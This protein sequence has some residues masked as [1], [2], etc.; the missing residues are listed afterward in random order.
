MVRWSPN[1]LYAHKLEKLSD[2][3]AFKVSSLVTQELGQ[4]SK[5]QDISLPHKLSK[6]F[7]VWLGVMYA[8]MCFIKWLQK[9]KMFTLFGGWS[10]SI[11]VSI[12]V[13]SM[14]SNSKGAVT[15][16]GHIGALAWVPSCWM[17]CLQLLIT[18][19][20]WESIPAHQNRSCSRYSVCSWPWC[21]ASQWHPFMA[22]TQWAVGP[23]ITKLLSTFQLVC[24][25]G[26]GLL[27]R[28]L[29][30]SALRE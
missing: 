8:I 10:T 18:F 23:W 19:C 17:Y 30:S 9:T 20:I 1:L 29:V 15:M 12:L 21:P 13:K 24:G 14:C 4:W 27:G 22:A 5:D 3:V 16:M 11:I 6:G 25:N 2:D 26:R 28:V 7:A